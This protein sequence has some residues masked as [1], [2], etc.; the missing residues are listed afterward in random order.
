ME[1]IT[2]EVGD[3]TI[4]VVNGRVLGSRKKY[5]APGLEIYVSGP[6][7]KKKRDMVNYHAIEQCLA[8]HIPLKSLVSYGWV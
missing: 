4:K 3:S 1:T 5:Y 6:V 7:P 2:I 8:R